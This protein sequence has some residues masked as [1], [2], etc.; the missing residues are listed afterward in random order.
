M[1][2]WLS[3]IRNIETFID[4]YERL[5]DVWEAGGANG[6][7]LGWLQFEC[8]QTLSHSRGTQR[9]TEPGNT[10][11]VFDPNPAIYAAF[12]APVPPAPDGDDR[13]LRHRLQRAFQAVVDRGWELWLFDPFIG[14]RAE[15]N[16]NASQIVDSPMRTL[17]GARMLDTIAA[18][19]M[20]TGFIIDGP[21]WGFEIANLD[22][23]GLAT[24]RRMLELPTDEAAVAALG[25]DLKSLIAAQDRLDARLHSL[26]PDDVRLHAPGG[27]VGAMELLG[28]PGFA[29][30]SKFR[31]D[32]LTAFYTY[33]KGLVD[34][35][36]G[37]DVGLAA[38]PR[39]PAL[40]P[41]AGYDYRRVAEIMDVVMTK[42]YYWQRGYDGLV[43][44]AWR[45]ASTLTAW[46]PGL[47]VRDAC[48]VTRMIFGDAMP[49]VD[50][51]IDFDRLLTPE[52][53][54][55]LTRL[56]AGRAAAAIG[57]RAGHVPWVDSGRAPHDGDP[58]TAAH[59]DA[60]L[61]AGRDVGV[62]QFTY[63]NSTNLTAADWTVLSHHCG[64]EWHPS[65]TPEWYPPDQ[66]TL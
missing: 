58:L 47:S 7:V 63:F 10:R 57:D 44:T 12:D 9:F 13:E 11:A 3:H 16:D 6:L 18:F 39:T 26:T 27:A 54:Y 32:A 66:P 60:T 46:N 31:V 50:E 23:T 36:A 62:D 40:G 42:L 1:K 64:T 29:E 22:H 15:L 17:M 34:E 48:Q 35:H 41:T 61:R 45:W 21:A 24:R 38:C 49:V 30:W 59:L 5:L 28:G 33:M 25:Y 37:R 8:G 43:G 53:L 19:P 65:D 2:F 51:L 4:D 55:D 52:Y 56:E 20:A 14:A